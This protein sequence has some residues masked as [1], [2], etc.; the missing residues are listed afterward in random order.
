MDAPTVVNINDILE[1]HTVLD[2]TCLDR[3]YLNAYVPKLQVGG[4]VY[5][6]LTQH[7]GNPVASPAIFQ[8]MGDRLRAAVRAFAEERSIPVLQLKKPDR[9]RWNDRKLDHVRPYL[10]K[11]TE[12]GVVAIVVAQEFQWVMM[13][14]NGAKKPKAVHFNFNKAERR[15]T[16]Y[17]F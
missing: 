14:T 3:I 10:D 17:Y 4:Q 1:G 2:L 7:R 13:G 9:S 6:F 8:K 11:A 15:V 12:P 5:Q 16:T